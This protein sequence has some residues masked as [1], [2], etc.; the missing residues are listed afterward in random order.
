MLILE[1]ESFDQTSA[2]ITN[3]RLDKK[4]DIAVL[5]FKKGILKKNHA[6]VTD[7]AIN[8]VEYLNEAQVN[9]HGLRER[10]E[11]GLI[12]T[13]KDFKSQ[14]NVEMADEAYSPD[15]PPRAKNS[16]NSQ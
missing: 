12:N 10:V 2:F 3:E 14:K 8:I 15:R 13:R 1:K 6:I 16:Q 4:I 11:K 5:G 9:I 7:K